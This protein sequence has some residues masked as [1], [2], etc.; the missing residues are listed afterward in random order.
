MPSRSLTFYG[1]SYLRLAAAFRNGLAMAYAHYRRGSCAKAT[2][3]NGKTLESPTG[4][5]GLVE[6]AVEIWGLETYC[7]GTFYSPAPSDVVLDVGANI[8]LFSAWLCQRASGIKVLAFEPFPENVSALRSNLQSWPNV[9]VHPCAVGRQRGTAQMVSVGTRSLD[10]QLDASTRGDTE[11]ITLADA[12]DRAG[13]VVTLLKM[14]IEGSEYDVFADE[15]PAALMR[16]IQKIALEWHEH[17]RPGVLALLQE[18]LSPTHEIV[19][20]TRD[21]E[22]YGML[23]ARLRS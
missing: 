10:H 1:P 20:I 18:R 2:L 19:S 3:W 16:R 11:V 15:P 17:V 9:Q 8:G 14:D 13:P 4:R 12:V 5:A 6:T 22:R 7:A 21:D 23:F